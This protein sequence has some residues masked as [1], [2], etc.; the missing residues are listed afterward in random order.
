MGPL[1]K[2]LV[3]ILLPGGLRE[4]V[5]D[6]MEELYEIRVRSQG[7]PSARP[8][9]SPTSPFLPNSPNPPTG[10][11]R[12]MTVPPSPRTLGPP[13]HRRIRRRRCRR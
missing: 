9:P 3:R 1:K 6:E 13:M 12:S 4:H 2:W 8:G 10:P 5:L 7:K 11:H